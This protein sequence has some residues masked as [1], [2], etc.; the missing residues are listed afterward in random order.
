MLP[1]GIRVPFDIKHDG[2]WHEYGI[3][4]KT[5]K[6]LFKLRLDVGDTRGSVIIDKLRLLDGS[7]NG[8]HAWPK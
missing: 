7:G 6:K 5:E 1:R 3:P 4:L 2:Q 8:V